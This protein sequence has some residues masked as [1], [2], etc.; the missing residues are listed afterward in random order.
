VSE[1]PLD[2]IGGE[3]VEGVGQRLVEAFGGPGVMMSQPGN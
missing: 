1:P 3:M 2:V